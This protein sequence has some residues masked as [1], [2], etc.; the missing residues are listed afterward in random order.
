MRQPARLIGQTK[1]W[2]EEERWR[3]VRLAASRPH[4]GR[5]G[6]QAGGCAGVLGKGSNICPPLSPHTPQ[7]VWKLFWREEGAA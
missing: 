6:L 5:G 4:T 2:R 1:T 3:I 7:R